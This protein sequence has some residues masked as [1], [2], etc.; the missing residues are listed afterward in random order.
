MG[1]ASAISVVLFILLV[2]VT[3]AQM[4]YLRAGASD[5]GGGPP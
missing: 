4:R 5:L 1:Y 2:G 3:L